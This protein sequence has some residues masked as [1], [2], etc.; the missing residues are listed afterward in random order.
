MNETSQ[1][2]LLSYILNCPKIKSTLLQRIFNRLNTLSTLGTH[3][4][5]LYEP[6]DCGP[7]DLLHELQTSIIWFFT[8]PLHFQYWKTLHW[9]NTVINLQTFNYFQPLRFEIQ[10]LWREWMRVAPKARRVG[11]CALLAF[12]GLAWRGAYRRKILVHQSAAAD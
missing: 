2:T 3:H 8:I 7:F 4:L 1:V 12:G 11:C 10:N 5:F 6:V 9:L